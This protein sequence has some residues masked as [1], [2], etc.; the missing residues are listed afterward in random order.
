MGIE[1]ALGYPC[2]LWPRW[3]LLDTYQLTRYRNSSQKCRTLKIF[4]SK[5]RNTINCK[6]TPSP[7]DHVSKHLLLRF[8]PVESGYIR[9]ELV[10][11]WQAV[12]IATAQLNV[13]GGI[14][15]M[16]RASPS[17]RY[18][19]TALCL[20]NCVNKKSW[21]QR[22]FISTQVIIINIGGQNKHFTKR[23]LA[24]NYMT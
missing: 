2:M 24:Q 14:W 18:D 3:T 19:K 13:N 8:D 5:N 4:S 7:E 20:T 16:R 10:R 23:Y 15:H 11:S 6:S 9:F 21:K 17:V 1:P 12:A 22:A